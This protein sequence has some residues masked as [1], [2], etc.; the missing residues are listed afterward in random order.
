MI[1]GVYLARSYTLLS[2][3][4]ER[5]ERDSFPGERNKSKL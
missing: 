2:E 5:P 4:L 3:A 1:P